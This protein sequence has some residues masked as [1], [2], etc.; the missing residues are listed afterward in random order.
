MPTLKEAIDV[1]VR[2]RS[3]RRLLLK[4]LAEL[5]DQGRIVEERSGGEILWWFAK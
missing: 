5:Q 3:T 4:Y 1:T 2:K